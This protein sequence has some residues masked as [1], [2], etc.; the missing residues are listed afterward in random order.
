MVSVIVPLFNAQRT[1]EECQKGL[2][3]QDYP[4]SH[5]EIIIADNNSTDDTASI[6]G[7]LPVKYIEEKEIQSSY[8]ARNQGIRHSRGDVLAF[9]DADCFAERTW[10]SRA[11]QGFSDAAVSCVAGGI[12]GAC[13]GNSVEQYLVDSDMLSQEFTLN[14]EFLPYAQTANALYRRAVLDRIGL[15]EENWT[16]GGDAD[17][18]WRMQIETHFSVHY[19]PEAIVFHK[20][21]ST[22]KGLWLQR[23]KWGEGRVLLYKK[24]KRHMKKRSARDSL[25][26]LFKIVKLLL[27]LMKLNLKF[28]GSKDR[29]EKTVAYFDLVSFLGT[30]AGMLLSSVRERT[31]CV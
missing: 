24:Y 7:N 21:R 12:R 17:L 11:I 18:A 20:H 10:L 6:V 28:T 29:W 13:P 4:R 30:K 25:F 22:V 16:S 8:A 27:R 1:V 2:L 26:D 31:Y 15:F 14:H 9:I 3:N 23:L 5:Y 19:V